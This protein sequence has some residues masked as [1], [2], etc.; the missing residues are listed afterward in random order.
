MSLKICSMAK[1]KLEKPRQEKE[2]KPSEKPLAHLIE[3]RL[4]KLGKL[5]EKGVNPYP[6]K[7]DITHYAGGV[8]KE[9]SDAGE[10]P[11]GNVKVAGRLVSFREMGKLSFAHIQDA[12]GKLQIVF[13]KNE[14]GE[15]YKDLKLLDIGDILGV[16]GP[17]FKTKRGEI[18][19]LV[20]EYQ[21]LSKSLRP[22]PEKYHGLKDIETRYKKRYLDLIMNRESMETF[23]KR[24]RIVGKIREFMDGNGFIEMETPILEKVYGGAAA[25]PFTTHLNYLDMNLFLRIALEIPLKKLLVGGYDKVYQIGRVFRNE[26]I[27][28]THNPE[29]TMIE[30]YWAYT[31]YNDMI[32][33]IEDMIKK[34]VKD[35]V[36]KEKITFRGKEIDLTNFSKMTMREAFEKYYGKDILDY[37][38]DQLKSIIERDEISYDGVLTR[39]DALDLIWKHYVEDNLVDPVFIVDYPEETSPLCKQ[40]RSL[41]GM[42]ER[43][44]L[45]VGGMELANIYSELNDP[46]RQKKLLEE[47]ARERKLGIE[48]AQPYDEDFVEALEYGMP[49]AS[50]M[51][52]GIDRLAMILLEKDSIKDVI[53]FP[54]V[55]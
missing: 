30:A 2:D 16:S 52:I 34:I 17:V 49:P 50:G 27:D 18:S 4:E 20:N 44:E 55:K 39:P 21:L 7:Y 42:I 15:R 46:I 31:D 33:L 41:P 6:Y 10:D 48:T 45:F 32:A 12:S 36:G 23:V 43:S 9:F 28:S 1:E 25:R 19:V 53:L 22:L 40:H 47:Q 3:A 54:F 29:F 11:K 35:V 37:G 38:L 5:K 24:A 14:L 13:R 8:K 51:G 26:S